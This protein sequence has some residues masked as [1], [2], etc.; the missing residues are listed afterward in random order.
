MEADLSSLAVKLASQKPGEGSSFS[1]RVGDIKPA[2]SS[3][4]AIAAHP[5]N[6]TLASLNFG[7]LLFVPAQLNLSQ[8]ARNVTFCVEA[9]WFNGA[10]VEGGNASKGWFSSG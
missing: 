2:W 4:K 8:R 5:V 10:S 1:P 6:A 3:S 7:F 9:N